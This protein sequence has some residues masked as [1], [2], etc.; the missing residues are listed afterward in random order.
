MEAA[1][2]ALIVCADLCAVLLFMSSGQV[3]SEEIGI[4]GSVYAIPWLFHLVQASQEFRCS[5]ADLCAGCCRAISLACL[6]SS[7]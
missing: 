3:T 7:S 4:L 5:L 2:T 1:D 6:F